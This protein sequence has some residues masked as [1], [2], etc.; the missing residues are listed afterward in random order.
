MSPAEDGG[1]VE[2]G[3]VERLDAFRDT[4]GKEVQ[5]YFA[6]FMVE[7]GFSTVEEAMAPSGA[8]F[9]FWIA[10]RWR[11]FCSPRRIPDQNKLLFQHEFKQWL[12]T[13]VFVEMSNVR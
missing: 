7:R 12:A 9:M 1:A 13:R 2:A 5:P 4:D 11:D 6:A 10:A 8:A 3:L